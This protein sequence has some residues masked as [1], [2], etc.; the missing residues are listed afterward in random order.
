MPIVLIGIKEKNTLRHI[1]AL[2]VKYV[3]TA[4]ILEIVLLLLSSVSFSGILLIA[5]AVTAISYMIGD[6]L[7]LSATNNLVATLADIVLAFITIYL[8]NF[9][10]SRG[11]IPFMSALIASV[12]IGFGEWFF[13]KIIDRSM[14][15]DTP[16]E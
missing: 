6:M 11:D 12:A 14:E 9:I 15:D 8:F 1:S 7:V 4:I 5:L 13:H 16:L 3:M 10:W 2:I